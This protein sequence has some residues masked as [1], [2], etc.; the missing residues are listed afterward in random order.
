MNNVRKLPIVG[1]VHFGREQWPSEPE[2][3]QNLLS[4]T[5]LPIKLSKIIYTV[6]ESEKAF[7]SLAFKFSNQKFQ[8]VYV[9]PPSNRSHKHT[10]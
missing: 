6:N 9:A 8:S 1:D 3:W 5:P 4:I 10:C 2:D 7:E